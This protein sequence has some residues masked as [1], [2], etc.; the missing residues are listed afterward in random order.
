[1]RQT[2]LAHLYCRKRRVVGPLHLLSRSE[3]GLTYALGFALA[4]VPKLFEAFLG[5]CGLRGRHA[6]SVINLQERN[7]DGI[8]DIE[9]ITPHFQVTIEAK[10]GGWPRPEQLNRYARAML[11]CGARRGMIVALGVPP[12]SPELSS[13]HKLQ[14]QVSLTLA[15]W[16]DILSLVNDASYRVPQLQ[17]PILVELSQLIQEVIGMQHYDREVLI[18]DLNTTW[19]SYD[20]YFDYNLYA[21]QASESAEPLFFAPCFTGEDRRLHNGIHY[22]S[23]VYYRAVFSKNDDEGIAEALASAKDAIDRKISAM[24]HRKGAIKEIAYLRDLPVKWRQGLRSLRTKKRRDTNAFFFL[25]NPIRL[26]Q[27]LQKQG[28]MVP[29]GFSMSLEHL[30]TS[31]A[32]SFKC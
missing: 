24:E 5:F 31:E 16:T 14:G 18:R 27:P 15:R 7:A 20:L 13:L 9:I 29:I 8:T 4:Q 2:N 32:A 6:G 1:M 12:Y 23:R 26:A 19:H 25:G 28:K 30:M 10:I 17:E 3:N 11:N 22:F 21:C